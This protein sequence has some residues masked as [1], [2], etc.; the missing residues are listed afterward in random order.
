MSFHSLIA[1][2]IGMAIFLV[3]CGAS[4]TSTPVPTFAPEPM[5]TESPTVAPTN[6]PRSEPTSSPTALP[7]PSSSADLA[8][9]EIRV[10]ARPTDAVT[11]ALVTVG[12]VEVKVPGAPR[13]MEHGRGRARKIRSVGTAEY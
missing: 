2:C 11:S 6:T 4:A 13:R 8:V 1:L 3:A 9:L 5:S 12:N 7:P 10:T